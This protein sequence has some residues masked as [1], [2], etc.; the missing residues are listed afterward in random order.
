MSYIGN[1]PTSIAFL[2]DLF[3]GTG[4]LSVFTMSTAPAT[5]SSI[6]VSITGIV[7]EPSTYAVS[8]T[9][10]TF[11]QA[12]PAGTGN[13]SI[14]YLGIPASGVTSTA[15]KTVTEFTATLAQT[16]F[17]VPSYTVG[18]I[19]VYRNGA[20]LGSA[21]YTAT[22]GTNVVL[23]V[24]ANTGDLI[25]TESFYVS[26]VLNAI[27]AV[28]GAVTSSYI[29]PN[30]T[31]SSPSY[32]GTLTGSTGILNIGS[33]QVYKDASGNVGIGTT[34]PQA[35]LDIAYSS[36]SLPALKISGAWSGTA[37]N[38][39]QLTNTDTTFVNTAN[40]ALSSGAAATGTIGL[41]GIEYTGIS[42]T[43]GKIGIVS[44]TGNGAY[45]L[46]ANN[47][48]F[49]YT[50]TASAPV[51]RMQIDASGNVGIGTTVT[52]NGLLNLV[53]DGRALFLA[54]KTQGAGAEGGEMAWARGTDGTA[55]WTMDVL[56]GA[57][58]TI[59]VFNTSA[60]GVSLASGTTAWGAY[61]DIR[62][63]TNVLPLRAVLSDIAGIECINYHLK[64]IDTDEDRIRIGVS[65]Q[66][67]VGKFDEVIDV[68][69][70]KK[71]P[72]DYLSVRYSDM[73][74]YLVKAIQELK[75]IIDTQQEQIN[76]LL[77][78]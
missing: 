22:T 39:L 28:A 8:G 9:T 7:Q 34:S 74:P 50:G 21:D 76:S 70:K 65:A 75:A 63:K 24:A 18:Y 14:R 57:A 56:A 51:E 40:I 46:A 72:T 1:T 58:P 68:T 16:I 52:S 33:G 4:S 20:R 59:R 30:V 73:I 29:V 12:P 41:A 55:F 6:L 35:K 67:L 64:D 44:L 53:V 77:G 42:A 15:Y 49:F 78:K 5:T 2:T 27:P 47:P 38:A 26:S 36:G 23:A 13:I 31:L 71:D 61:S 60:T 32:T 19:T 54:A 69:Q 17:T 43:S 10:L 45:I 11:S 3:T 66:S 25:A 48:I 62:L 37:R